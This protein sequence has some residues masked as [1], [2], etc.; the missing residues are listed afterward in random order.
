MAAAGTRDAFDRSMI[1]LGKLCVK[2]TIPMDVL[3]VLLT[4]IFTYRNLP[5]KDR[6]DLMTNFFQR[7][8]DPV[9]DEEEEIVENLEEYLK[10]VG[11]NRSGSRHDK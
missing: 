8:Y 9:S 5:D 10:K 7:F 3:R 6:D 11:E 1:E 2:E 4:I